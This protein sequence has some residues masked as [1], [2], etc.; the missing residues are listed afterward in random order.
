MTTHVSYIFPS[1]ENTWPLQALWD[2]AIEMMITYLG[3]DPSD[4]Q[5]KVVDII[6]VHA[7]FKFLGD[8][9]KDYLCMVVDVNNDDM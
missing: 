3:V 9:Y 6:C 8:L 7:R 4:V 1:G 5:K 2:E